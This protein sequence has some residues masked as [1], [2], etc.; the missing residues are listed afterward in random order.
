MFAKRIPQLFLAARVMMFCPRFGKGPGVFSPGQDSRPLF[1][2]ICL[3]LS[4][5]VAVTFSSP[6]TWALLML[7]TTKL[8][9]VA[10]AISALI[11]S[12]I[13]ASVVSRS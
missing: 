10:T 5:L 13:S 6:V 11:R 3:P 7:T 1:R 2:P 4:I 8:F 9:Q 12:P